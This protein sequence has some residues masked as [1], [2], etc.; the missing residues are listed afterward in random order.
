MGEEISWEIRQRAEELYVEAGLTYEQVA[1]KTGVS[2]SQLKRWGRGNPDLDLPS[3]PERRRRYRQALA[4]IRRDTV[5]L[6]QRLI[7]KAL[8]SL[9]PQDVFAI[10]SIE[11]VA[12]RAA[13][14]DM[15]E[16]KLSS[17]IS[18][19]ETAIKTP[20][21][22][23]DALQTVIEKKINILLTKPQA[24]SLAAVKDIKQAIELVEKMK[25]K[26]G[27]Q[28]EKSDGGDSDADRRRLI[29]EV[30][31]ILGVAR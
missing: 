1:A 12:A 11:A 13:K 18:S 14:K 22:A 24:M 20:E 2:V 25:A 4:D 6:R 15:V 8:D 29:A 21:D 31:R 28:K 26:Y 27:R 10:S 23:I 30:D 17:S 7:K 9:N 16:E 5:L 3:W 19:P